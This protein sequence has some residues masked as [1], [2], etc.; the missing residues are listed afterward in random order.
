MQPS[1]PVQ[2]MHA[3]LVKIG[4][5]I[6]HQPPAFSQPCYNFNNAYISMCY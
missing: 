6:L 3:Q 1:F 2:T 5:M 4:Y